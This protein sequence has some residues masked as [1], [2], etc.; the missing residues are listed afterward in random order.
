MIH[1]GKDDSTMI[2]NHPQI[3]TIIVDISLPLS[4][5]IPA[6]IPSCSCHGF[7]CLVSGDATLLLSIPH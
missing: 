4:L 3:Y 7:K 1:I 2:Y 5:Y 6:T